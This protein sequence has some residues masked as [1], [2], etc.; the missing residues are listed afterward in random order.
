MQQLFS[1][2]H[3][4]QVPVRMNP[5]EVLQVQAQV[6]VRGLWFSDIPDMLGIRP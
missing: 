4:D 2:E 1:P 5:S 6:I 3:E